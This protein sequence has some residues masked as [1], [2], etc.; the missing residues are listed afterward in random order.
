MKTSV[1]ERYVVAAENYGRLEGG[2]WYD[3]L[4]EARKEAAS[5]RNDMDDPEERHAILILKV[6]RV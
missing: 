5:M 6:L 1:P 4:K 3:T 2:I